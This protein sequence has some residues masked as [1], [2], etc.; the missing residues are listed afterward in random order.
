MSD[1]WQLDANAAR[2]AANHVGNAVLD[3]AHPDLGLLLR[4][5]N[6]ANF[7]EPS[8]VVPQLQILG[9]TFGHRQPLEPAQTDAY[10]RGDDIVATYE[11]AAPQ[12]IRM[13]V[14]WRHLQPAEFAPDWSAHVLSAFDLILSLNTSLLDSNPQS[15][16]RSLLSPACM[17][18]HLRQID[19]N[20]LRAEPLPPSVIAN[21]TSHSIAVAPGNGNTGCFIARWESVPYGYV[22]MVHPI[23]FCRSTIVFSSR[24]PTNQASP[25]KI[26]STVIEHHLFQERLEKGVILRARVRSAIVARPHDEA[27]AVT[28]YQQFAAAEP[29]LTV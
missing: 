14:Y 15:N 7:L 25:L 10:V 29:P 12:R 5:S 3:L 9:A 13:Q 23:D 22:E 17:M 16:V 24:P 19:S 4:L 27:V 6:T 2:L 26:S 8:A 20:Q 18:F 11:E 28:A 1:V 21:E